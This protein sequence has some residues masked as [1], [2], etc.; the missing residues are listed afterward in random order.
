MSLAVP[1]LGE[2]EATLARYGAI[3]GDA[4]SHRLHR[5][6]SNPWLDGL[7]ADYPSRGGKSLRPAILVATCQAFGGS[8]REALG[9]AVSIELLH[10]A[11][12]VHDDIQDDSELR[13]GLPTLHRI[14]GLPL[15]L[16]AGDALAVMALEPLRVDTSLG[17]RLSRRLSDEFQRMALQTIDGQAKELGWR[18]DPAARLTDADYM[19]MVGLKTCWYTTVYPLRAGALI[20]SRATAPLGDLNRFGFYLG[21]AFQI[22][23][24]LLNLI[25]SQESYGKELLGDIREGKRTLVLIT[26][27][28]RACGSDRDFL[29]DFLTRPVA[30]RRQADVERVLALMHELGCIDFAVDYG[31]G[32][33]AAAYDAFDTAFRAVADSEHK[34]FLRG[35]VRY[36]LE[37]DV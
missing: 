2:V 33:G 34:A 23:D 6:D 31:R 19:D 9:A 12:L 26:V 11:F 29:H 17:S 21:A 37:R 8:V 36:M 32:V 22:R 15:A 35:L 30:G 5:A 20:G 14:H 13:R 3:V 7:V 18:Q 10:N 16:N 1:T 4:V 25:G 28:E 24:D 27:L